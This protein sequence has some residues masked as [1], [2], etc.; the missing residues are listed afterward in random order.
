M[1]F[2]EFES[3]QT[4]EMLKA[5]AFRGSESEGGRGLRETREVEGTL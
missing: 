1:L 4:K 3:K 5:K 2:V